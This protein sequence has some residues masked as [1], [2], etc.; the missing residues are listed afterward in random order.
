MVSPRLQRVARHAFHAV[1]SGGVLV[2][3]LAGDEDT[4]GVHQLAGY[5]VLAALLLRVAAGC[6]WRRGPL[7][8]PVPR[9]AAVAGWTRGLLRGDPGVVAGFNPLVPLLAAMLLA[10]VAAAAATGAVS[11]WTTATE[12]LHEAL[13]EA[14]PWLVVAHLAVVA[15][16]PAIRRLARRAPAPLR[17][18]GETP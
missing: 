13:G 11:D 8:L 5:T 14:M 17:A 18:E 6:L 12:D 3:W 10:A 4:Y 15:A 16:A 1:L 2:A 7:A 9:P